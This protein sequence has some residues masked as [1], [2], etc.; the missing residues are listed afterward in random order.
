[1][2]LETM[3][4]MLLGFGAVLVV[5]GLGL[6]LASRLGLGRMPGDIHIERGNFSFSFPIVTCII[7]SIVASIILN[8]LRR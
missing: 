8:L 6:L 3:G 1:M 5:T 7:V 4:K 2:P